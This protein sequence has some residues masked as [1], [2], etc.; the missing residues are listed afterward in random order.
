MI[1]YS[2]EQEYWLIRSRD[3]DN[4][5][6][7]SYELIS[8]QL[9]E[10][11]TPVQNGYGYYGI[12][13]YDPSEDKVQCHICGKWYI[14]LGLHA[15]YAHGVP[16]E[17][18]KQEFELGKRGLCS[19]GYSNR[20]QEIGTASAADGHLDEYRIPIGQI[21]TGAVSL[22]G[23]L[24]HATKM[25]TQEAREKVSIGQKKSYQDPDRH[26]K[27]AEHLRKVKL[28]NEEL[29]RINKE[30][31]KDGMKPEARQ[32]LSAAHWARSQHHRDAILAF[33]QSCPGCS[34]L[35]I[36]AELDYNEGRRCHYLKQLK[37]R[38][39]IYSTGHS[40]NTRYYPVEEN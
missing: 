35:D 1:D 18:Y 36:T 8:K 38:G 9:Y 3:E 15:R 13:L 7:F 33:V 22:A 12:I 25:Q 29:S 26:R 27:Q 31:L 23:K 32:K 20:H 6:V 4:R 19:V 37:D 5:K 34:G 10:K 39:L 21:P 30:R 28:S 24:R 16:A 40:A 17:N 2:T 14:Q 11:L